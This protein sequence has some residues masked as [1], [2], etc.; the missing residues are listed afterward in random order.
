MADATLNPHSPPSWLVFM[1]GSL[2]G[3]VR[4]PFASPAERETAIALLRQDDRTDWA[5]TLLVIAPV[6]VNGEWQ[7]DIHSVSEEV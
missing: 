2:P 1:E 4:G 5:E 6:L 7:L 3:S